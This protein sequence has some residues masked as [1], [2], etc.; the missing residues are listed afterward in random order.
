MITVAIVDDHP[1]VRA[2]LRAVLGS[3]AD[4]SLIA[5]GSC[6]ADAL[7]L[8]TLLKPDVLVLDLNLPDLNGLEVTRQIKALNLPTGILILTVHREHVSVFGLLESGALGYVLKDEALET[9]V[10]AVR[11]VAQGHHWLS[12]AVASQV[13]RRVVGRSSGPS[14]EPALGGKAAEL[15]PREGE[16]LR[17][18][19]QGLDN[20][21]IASRLVLT[22]R[23]VQNHV[24]TI[25][26]KLGVSSRT[27]AALYAIQH[28]L[29]GLL[30]EEEDRR[31]G[32]DAA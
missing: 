7:R 28:G 8:V 9:L 3:A 4:L 17:L 27:E 12:P 26:S 25:Y 32:G 31:G 1:V 16:V 14:Q 30:P 22:T 10:S 5:E 15:T 20:T 21:T 29:S 24:S 18:I 13:V 19:A 11:A 6:G 23:T 2:G